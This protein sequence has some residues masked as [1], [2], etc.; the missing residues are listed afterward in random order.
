MEIN[1]SPFHQSS[2]EKKEM[3]VKNK[4]EIIFFKN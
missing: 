1:I 4:M 2:P 3:L